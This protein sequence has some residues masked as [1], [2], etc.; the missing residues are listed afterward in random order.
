MRLFVTVLII[1]GGCGRLGFDDSNNMDPM[2][3]APGIPNQTPPTE[4]LLAHWT[5]DNMTAT[6]AMSVTSPDEATCATGEC[7]A[8]V[9]GVAGVA[10]QF[11][12]VNTCYH[13]PSL[14]SLDTSS[15]TI[16]LWAN[17][18]TTALDQPMVMRYSG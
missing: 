8:A 11:D 7:A 5:F 17:L 1:A 9:P 14:A 10:A 4:G 2:A 6:G 13:V 3:P 18:T 12:G 15:Y 16:S